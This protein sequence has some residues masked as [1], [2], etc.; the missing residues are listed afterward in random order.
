MKIIKVN[1]AQRSYQIVIGFG[2]IKDLGRYIQRLNLGTGAYI[3]TNPLIRKKCGLRLLRSLNNYDINSTFNIVADSEKT[4]SLSSCLRVIQSLAR[5]DQKKGC[6]VI[7]FGGGVV[8]DLSSFIASIYKRGIPYIQVPT[9]LLSC[10]DSSIGGKTGVDLKCG[11]NLIG[12]FYQPRL[13]LTELSFLKSLNLRQVR[14]GLA[15]VIKYAIIKDKNM[16]E[17][18]EKNSPRILSLEKS[19]LEYIVN[20]CAQI[21]A[22]IIEQ[23]EREEKGIRT[24]LNFGHTLGHAIEAAAAYQKYNHGEAIALGMILASRISRKIKLID[25]TTLRR[26]EGLISAVGL[27]VFMKGLC[28]KDVIKA[29]Y[30]DK[31]FIDGLNRFVLIK[32][33]GRTVIKK[34]LALGII[35]D[36]LIARMNPQR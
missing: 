10:V 13:V 4:K 6:F 34:D 20:C 29:Y 26:I 28:L 5:F 23:D 1:L 22:R 2:V 25:K 36:S 21:K 11:K 19:A 35:K 24:I 27:P 32:G 33:I 9:T 15:E 3:I 18:L 7:A 14:A 8:G 31:K 12:S 17:Y 16:F 30:R